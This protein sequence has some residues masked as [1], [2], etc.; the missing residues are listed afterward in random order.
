MT[1]TSVFNPQAYADGLAAGRADRRLGRRSEVAWFG[2]ELDPRYSA[3]YHE[4]TT[5]H[6]GPFTWTLTDEL[7]AIIGRSRAETLAARRARW[8]Y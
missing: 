1:T 7:Q 4:N 5:K 3:D 6:R 8:G 2:V